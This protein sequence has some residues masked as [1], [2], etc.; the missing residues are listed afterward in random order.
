MIRAIIIRLRLRAFMTHRT[1]AAG[2]S[3]HHVSPEHSDF[4]GRISI[5]P[6]INRD[7]DIGL[8]DINFPEGSLPHA[9]QEIKKDGYLPHQEIQFNVTHVEEPDSPYRGN[10]LGKRASV[11]A[12]VVK[13]I[14]AKLIE[15]GDSVTILYGGGVMEIP[16]DEY[17]FKIP[18]KLPPNNRAESED[19]LKRVIKTTR[20]VRKKNR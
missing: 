6:P 16:T 1:I 8:L 12:G 11:I 7:G 9:S 4:S 14:A 2:I 18:K 10:L 13:D 3:K 20:E 15:Q 17:F 19:L 5:E